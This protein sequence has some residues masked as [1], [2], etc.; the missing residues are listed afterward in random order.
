MLNFNKD[1]ADEKMH[2]TAFDVILQTYSDF[3]RSVVWVVK[4]KNSSNDIWQYIGIELKTNNSFD[5]KVAYITNENTL[6]ST[7]IDS[8]ENLNKYFYMSIMKK[9]SINMKEKSIDGKFKTQCVNFIG[10]TSDN[11][12][13]QENVLNFFNNNSNT[14]KLKIEKCNTKISNGTVNENDYV[15]TENE[16]RELGVCNNYR[17]FHGFQHE[18]A[19]P[20]TFPSLA[21]TKNQLQANTSEVNTIDDID[22]L[23][24]RNGLTPMEDVGEYASQNIKKPHDGVYECA[25]WVR[26]A[27]E[28]KLKFNTSDRPNSACRYWEVLRWWGF[29]QIYYG[30]TNDFPGTFKNGD[31]IVTEGLDNGQRSKMHGHI[32]IYYQGKWYAD[33]M[34]KNPNVYA[35]SGDRPCFIYR[36]VNK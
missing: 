12:H 11:E 1:G 19:D 18:G 26:R 9:Y 5:V 2:G 33:K 32:Q 36:A 15:L 17:C 29:T 22:I 31:I 25:K 28:A 20:Y 14:N 24:R 7:N 3:L 35:N 21:S 23:L 13:W 30:M 16:K 6:Q 10:L 34:Y 8:Y 27:L 4:D